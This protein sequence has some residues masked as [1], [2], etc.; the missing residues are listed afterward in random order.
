M[1]THAAAAPD[2]AMRWAPRLLAL[3]VSMFLAAFS[4]D[5]FDGRPVLQALPDF[6]IHLLPAAIV[7]SVVAL[8]WHREWIG[9]TLFT[10]FAVAY[11]V[12]AREH[13]AWI[14]VISGPLLVTAALYCWTWMLRR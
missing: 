11:A 9:A 12:A 7:A 8:A 1:N 4:F 10:A 5:A 13:P 3:I 14:A 6:A 2:R